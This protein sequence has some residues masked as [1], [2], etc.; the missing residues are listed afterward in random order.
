MKRKIIQALLRTPIGKA[1]M[2]ALL[3]E[4]IKWMK[5]VLYA[6]YGKDKGPRI[7]YVANFFDMLGEGPID[8]FVNE[9]YKN[10]DIEP[11][12]SFDK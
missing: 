2:K 3:L 6:R 5:T 7:D 12:K 8:Y 10:T 11:L 1:I 9:G 4:F